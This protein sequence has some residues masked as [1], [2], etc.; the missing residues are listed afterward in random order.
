MVKK[1]IDELQNRNRFL[2]EELDMLKANA[3]ASSSRPD[4]EAR[5]KIL[6]AELADTLSEYESM[7]KASIEA[8]HSDAEHYDKWLLTLSSGAFGISIA[9][10][11]HIA[12]HPLADSKKYLVIAWAALWS[13][14]GPDKF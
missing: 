7:T 1:E 10:L 2:N 4:L 9:F 6:E 12:P 3:A 11:Q 13:G 14:D 8:E 5:C